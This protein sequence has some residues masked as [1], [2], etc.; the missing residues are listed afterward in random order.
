MNVEKFFDNLYIHFLETCGLRG[1]VE[2]K[3]TIAGAGVEV[4]CAMSDDIGRAFSH[5]SSPTEAL[6]LSIFAWSGGPDIRPPDLKPNEVLNLVSDRFR[7]VFDQHLFSGYDRERRCGFF[8]AP[9]EG[10]LTAAERS[11][12]F[13]N[14]LHWWAVDGGGQLTHAAAVGRP[15][16]G[17]LLVGKGGSGKSTAALACLASGMEYVSDDYCVILPQEVGPAVAAS[18]YNT[19]K[20]DDGALSKIPELT[21]H[22]SG[23]EPGPNHKSVLT[24]TSSQLVPKMFI[25]AILVPKVV[26]SGCE[27]VPLSKAET[28][29]ALAPSTI[30]Q[31]PRCDTT[32]P[33][34]SKLVEQTPCYELLMGPDVTLVPEAVDRILCG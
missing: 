29:R 9:G 11:T 19:G 26:P 28:L 2:C 17:V 25:K 12:P 34:L 5:L 23:R 1:S 15:T 20:L 16:G 24:L 33:F 31:L 21:S 27:V 7:A 4:I 22:V 18:L 30:F 13:R 3:F 14:I 10:Y 32:F 8:W 6:R